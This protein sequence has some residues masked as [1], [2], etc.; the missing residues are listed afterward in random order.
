MIKERLEQ[1]EQ[2]TREGEED[3]P[4]GYVRCAT[5]GELVEL[6]SEDMINDYHVGCGSAR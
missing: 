3:T 1:S 2:E 6:N 5:C 4:E